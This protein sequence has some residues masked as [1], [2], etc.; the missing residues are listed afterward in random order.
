[1][2]D[3]R[4]EVLA[5]EARIRP[6]VRETPLEEA[7]DLGEAARCEAF[8]KLENLQ[9][10]GSFKLRGALS[11]LLALDAA[12]RRRGVVAASTGNHGLAVAYGLQ[13][14]GIQGSIY[15]PENASPQ[16]VELLRRYGAD[17]RFHSTEPEETERRARAEAERNG[18]VYLSPYND[19]Q[20]VGGQ[21]TIAV[22]LMQQLPAVECV[23]AAVGGGGLIGG[24]AGYLKAVRPGVEVIGCLP[25]H[26]PVMYAS[27]RAGRIVEMPAKPTL[28]D[29]TA[30]G[31]EAGALTF[32]LCRRYVD[33]WV[34]VEEAQIRQAMRRIFEEHRLVIEGSAGVPVAAFL[35]I[36]DRLAGKK[37]ALILC[38]GNVDV[39]VFKRLVC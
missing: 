31:I 6:L 24:V 12:Q 20:V 1:M 29:G 14:L 37:V 21:G 7:F 9:A 26:S 8:L 28:S 15:L 5:A 17:V 33:D 35:Q 34:L 27:I 13:K 18:Q 16:K 38:G 11:K 32:D 3:V 23:L 25:A 2:I 10:T 30:G 4:E 39:E 36:K 19:P 22:E